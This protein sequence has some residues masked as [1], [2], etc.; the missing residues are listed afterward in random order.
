MKICSIITGATR[1]DANRVF[2][3]IKNTLSVLSEYDCEHYALTYNTDESEQLKVMIEEE[4]LDVNFHLID[5]ITEKIGSHNG[6]NYRMVRCIE[7]LAEKVD[8]LKSFD[9]VLRHRIDCELL[10]IEIPE[11]IEENT[12]YAPYMSWGLPFDNI[13]LMTPEVFEKVFH[14]NEKTFDE[15]TPHHTI[16][17]SIATHSLNTKPLNFK[18]ILYQGGESEFMGI[19][20]WS[21]HNRTFH[22]QNKWITIH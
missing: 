13:G 16:Q 11:V 12:Y 1:P 14:T 9:V 5:P 19:P 10:S 2:Q 21:K 6:N 7:L 17:K 3:N 15:E 4:K 20:Q 22:Y 18:K 8:N